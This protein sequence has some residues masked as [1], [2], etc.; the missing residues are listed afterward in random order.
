MWSVEP[1]QKEGGVMEEKKR[2]VGERGQKEDPE[3]DG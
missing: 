2:E 3:S 1:R